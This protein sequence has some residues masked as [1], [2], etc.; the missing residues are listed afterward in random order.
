MEK[1]QP[2]EHGL[3]TQSAIQFFRPLNG[4][5]RQTQER[6]LATGIGAASR[7]NKESEAGSRATL[8]EDSV[9]EIR[10]DLQEHERR[11][12]LIQGLRAQV[13]VLF[14][15][16]KTQQNLWQS[17]QTELVTREELKREPKNAE[18]KFQVDLVRSKSG[19]ALMK[20]GLTNSERRWPNN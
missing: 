20:P 18:S 17:A 14:S 5:N 7:A 4:Q 16:M 15:L 11:L 1:F 6:A 10:R 13:A 9:N 12:G 2:L 8:S 19:D 3:E